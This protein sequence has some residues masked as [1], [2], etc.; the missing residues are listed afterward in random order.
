MVEVVGLEITFPCSSYVQILDV[1]HPLLSHFN[2]CCFGEICLR[3]L[4]PYKI[5]FHL[6]P[7]DTNVCIAVVS[8]YSYNIYNI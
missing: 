8:F 1:C 4:I 3:S 5:T 6:T 7:H 2:R